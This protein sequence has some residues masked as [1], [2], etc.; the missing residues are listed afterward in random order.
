[1]QYDYDFLTLQEVRDET[2]LPREAIYTLIRQQQFPKPQLISKRN[3]WKKTDI[4][5]W[6]NCRLDWS[7]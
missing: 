5:Q 6:M 3:M 2:G 4:K 1:M 7:V